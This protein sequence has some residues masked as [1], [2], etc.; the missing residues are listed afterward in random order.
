MSYFTGLTEEEL[1]LF[2]DLYELTMA[3]AYRAE[4]MTERALFTLHFRKLPPGRNFVLA[5]GQHYGALLASALHFPR[6]QVDRLAQLDM[7]EDDFLEWLSAFRFS[8][9]IRVMPE[10]TPVFPHEPLLEVDA[11]VAEGQLLETL[12][13]NYVN[14][15]TVLASKAA[16]MV[17][18]A[19]G[20]PVVDFG[21]RR[22]HGYDAALRG[23]RA[24]R[25]AGL[26]ATSNV[27]GSFQHGLAASGTMAHSFI[28]AH[29]DEMEAFRTYARL[30]PG[31]TLLVD[32]YDTLGGVDKVIRLVRDEGLKVNAIRL[33]SGDLAQ[34]ARDAR[35]KL[36]E[37]GLADIRIVVSSGLDEWSIRDM[38]EAGAP[39][40]GFGVGTKLGVSEDAPA[41]DF[42]YKLTE[43]AGEPR[44]KNSPGKKLLPGRKQVWRYRDRDGRYRYDEIGRDREEREGE[45]LLATVVRDGEPEGPG[46][47]CE[48]SRERVRRA[49]NDMPERL[50]D[51]DETDQPYEVR[52]SDQLENLYQEALAAV[53]PDKGGS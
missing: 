52:I 47:D 53:T 49:L 5:C 48:A 45:A 24:Y 40:D 16:R 34:L 12:L 10:G 33:D 25:T 6:E 7:F 4:G 44:L 11:P 41:M 3:R 17:V 13:M 22:M 20:R 1:G 19:D 31:T 51:L 21:M 9:D 50:L 15:E 2:V 39:V 18:A 38:V 36:D 29:R 42:A 23:V 27:L 35:Q 8:G 43:Y 28:Q 32:T 14:T 46:P 37:A 26:A 30:Y